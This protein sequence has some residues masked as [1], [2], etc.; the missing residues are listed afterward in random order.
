MHRVIF[1]E[2]LKYLSEREPKLFNQVILNPLRGSFVVKSNQNGLPVLY[3]DN[4]PLEDEKDP[5]LEARKNV[6][7]FKRA[8]K[9]KVP[10]ELKVFGLGL[11][12]HIEELISHFPETK[13]TVFEPEPMF[14]RAVCES[15]DMGSLL[16]RVEFRIGKSEIPWE[17]QFDY[18]H[19]PSI[20]Y[21]KSFLHILKKRSRITLGKIPAFR[22]NVV[23]VGPVYGGTL[24]TALFLRNAFEALDYNVTFLDPSKFLTL[25]NH[26]QADIKNERNQAIILNELTRLLSRYCSSIIADIMPHLVIAVAQAPLLPEELYMIREAGILTSMW[27][28]ENYRIIEYWK[29]MAKRYD[30]FFIIQKGEFEE[31]L[32][33]LGVTNHHYVPLAA[34]TDIH[35]PVELTEEDRKRYGSAVSFMGAGYYNRRHILKS[36]ADQDLKLWGNGWQNSGALESF[37][38]EGGR[39]I[40]T[41]EIVKV[42]NASLINLNIHSSQ[43]T[44]GLEEKKDYINPRTYEIAACRAFQL[45]DLRNHLKDQFDLT[46]ELV[47]FDSE[48]ELRRLVEHFLKNPKEREEFAHSAY[49]RVVNEHTYVHRVL[50]MLEFIWSK[51]PNNWLSSVEDLAIARNVMDT[52]AEGDPDLKRFLSCMP[53]RTFYPLNEIV[54][55]IEINKGRLSDYELIFLMMNEMKNELRA[56]R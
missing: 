13:I 23:V 47:T 48:E 17:I 43:T 19:L 35:R 56:K 41:E 10:H 37:I 39:R 24:G 18:F 12:Y 15:R 11:A 55:L 16:Q 36:L 1:E 8:L 2:N 33:K 45:V 42:F 25:Y 14:L 38:Q 40:S 49:R 21:H 53:Q 27:F 7:K 34:D 3:V 5:G 46:D 44:K 6:L 4:K 54:S 31:I 52:L 32:L 29:E 9:G 51:R 22:L 20:S 28:V 30:F 26:V 50:D